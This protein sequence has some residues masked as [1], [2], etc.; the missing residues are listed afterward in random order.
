MRYCNRCKVIIENH[1]DDCP[2]CNQKTLKHD[3]VE[4]QDFPIQK[5]V[6]EHINKKIMKILVYLSITLVG[7]NIVINLTYPF[8]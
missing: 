8:K 7:T 6:G 4:E 2:L 5:V 3:E 1:L